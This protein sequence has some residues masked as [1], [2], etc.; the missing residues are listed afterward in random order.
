VPRTRQYLVSGSFRQTRSRVGSSG[1]RFS[2]HTDNTRFA[3]GGIRQLGFERFEL[4][5]AADQQAEM[6]LAPENDARRGM[7][8]AQQPED[9]HRS[10]SPRT[11]CRPSDVA[12][13]NCWAAAAV[14]L[15]KRISPGS[16]ICS[17]R[18][19]MR[20]R[21]RNVIGLVHAVLDRLT[22]TTPVWI[23]TRIFKSGSPSRATDACMANAA[24]Q[25]RTA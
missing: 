5:G 20:R 17:M 3:I 21:P 13:T 19:Q 8:D 16:A 22:M 6:P 12:S 24:A 1:S 9:L 23:P 7:P 2:G 10:D 25:A 18:R 15:V 11:V 4:R 14:S